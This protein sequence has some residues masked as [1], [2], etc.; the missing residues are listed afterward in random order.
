MS[1]L[2]GSVV[3]F[4]T[5]NVLVCPFGPTNFDPN[6][7]TARMTLNVRMEEGET[8]NYF[9]DLAM[10]AVRYLT[11]NSERLFGVGQLTEVQVLSKYHPCLKAPKDGYDPLLHAKISTAEPNQ[12]SV[13][14]WTKTGDVREPPSHWRHARV[15]LR[16]HVSHLWIMSSGFGLTVKVLDVLVKEEGGHRFECPF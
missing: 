2:D 10:W 13:R 7:P 16:F 11:E 14:Y 6:A 5:K 4:Q 12:H 9:R 15:Q 1:A 3:I 8:C